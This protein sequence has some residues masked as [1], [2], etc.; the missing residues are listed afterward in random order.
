[1]SSITHSLII[2]C[3]SR[4]GYCFQIRAD[5]DIDNVGNI[6]IWSIVE[7]GIG[8]TASSLPSLGRLLKNRFHTEAS[9]G[10]PPVVQ[11]LPYSGSNKATITSNTSTGSR[12]FHKNGGSSAVGD[13]DRDR[14]DDG[15]SSRKIYVQVDLEM[16][17]L[18]RPMTPRRSQGS[19][20]EL[21][22]S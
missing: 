21:V 13:E 20:D 3:V 18:E 11:A 15:S 7:S 19:E 8:I 2:T 16:Q 12:P 17:S 9:S 22:R 14:C 1:M 4:D 5:H 10:Q 6:I